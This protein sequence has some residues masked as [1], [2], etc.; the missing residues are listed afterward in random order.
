MNGNN[1]LDRDALRAWVEQS[2]AEQGIPVHI[3]DPVLI[4]SVGRLL[5]VTGSIV[6]HPS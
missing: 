5:S 1:P 4:A 2:C 3:T 6:T